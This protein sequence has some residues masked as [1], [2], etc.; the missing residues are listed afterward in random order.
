MATTLTLLSLAVR[1]GASVIEALE[2]VARVSADPVRAHLATV[3]AALR[4]GLSATDAWS[5]VP[6]AWTPA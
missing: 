3:A 2:R 1:G 5:C 4:W 6:S